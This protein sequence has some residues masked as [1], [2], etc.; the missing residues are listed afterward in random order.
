MSNYSFSG[1]MRFVHFIISMILLL[2]YMVNGQKTWGKHEEKFR[3]SDISPLPL[4]P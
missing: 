4:V 1:H 2:N 3:I